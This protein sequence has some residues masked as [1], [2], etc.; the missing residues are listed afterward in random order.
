VSDIRNQK[1]H[2]SHFLIRRRS[3]V[4][5]LITFTPYPPSMITSWICS[6][7]INTKMVGHWLSKTIGLFVGLT[8]TLVPND[9]RS[10]EQVPTIV[11]VTWIIGN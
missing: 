4:V 3:Q 11:P 6:P 2:L 10:G 1:E 8:K 7:W 5:L 9:C